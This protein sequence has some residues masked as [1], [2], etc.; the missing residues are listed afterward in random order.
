MMD[1][2]IHKE[3]SDMKD[4]FSID[5]MALMTG[6]STRTIRSYIADGFL[7]G[8]KSSGAWQ[9]TSEQAD[10][11]LQNKAVRPTL[12]SKKNATVY[13]FLGAPHKEQDMMCVVLDLPSDET[14]RAAA[15]FC[16]Y[17]CKIEAKAELRFASDRLGKT[18]RVILSGSDSDVMDLLARYYKER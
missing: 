2:E 9:F 15:L 4:S 17:M 16:K 14:G 13:D 7:E 12:R 10:A 5:D 11:F 3:D 18:A 1:I 8:D 6:L